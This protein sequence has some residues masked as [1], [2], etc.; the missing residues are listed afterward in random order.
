MPYLWSLGQE[1]GYA[2]NYHAISHPSLPNYL[3][4]AGG[5]TFG[6][7]DDRDPSVHPITGPSVYDQAL[8]HGETAR[9]YAQSMPS[10]CDGTNSSTYATKHNPWTYFVDSRRRCNTYD[11]PASQLDPGNLPNIATLTPNLINDGHDGTPTQADNYLKSVLP[12]IFAS[13]DFTTGRL[14]VVITTDESE[15]SDPTNHVLTVVCDVNLHA[16]VVT[17]DLNHYS[18]SRL[19]SQTIGARALSA[20]TTAPDMR[21]AFGL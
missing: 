4:I 18:L 11:V 20:A 12:P 2:T 10:N 1:Y 8:D 3:A 21:T 13:S 17:A 14:V 6:I 15:A 5:S 16:K 19:Y 7:T 9:A